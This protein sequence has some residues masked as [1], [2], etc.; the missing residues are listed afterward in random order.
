MSIALDSQHLSE[1]IS[2]EE[3]EAIA[4]Q[5][6]LAHDM[7]HAGT[8][9]GNDF[10]GWVDLPVNYDREEFARIKAAAAKASLISISFTSSKLILFCARTFLMERPGTV[11]ISLVG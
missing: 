1:F 11:A 5:V 7:L 2:P 8:G 4:P 10:L 3:Y 9:L 6:K